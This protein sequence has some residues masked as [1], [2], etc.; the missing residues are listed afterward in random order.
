MTAGFTSHLSRRS[1]HEQ[2]LQE[3]W[4]QCYIGI[5]DASIYIH[6][7]DQLVNGDNIREGMNAEQLAQYIKETKAE[8]RFLRAYYYWELLRKYGPIPILPDE[9]VNFTDS[10][11]ELSIPRSR[12]DV[13]AEY[14]ASELALA[15]IDLPRRSERTNREVC[16]PVPKEQHWRL[17]PKYIC[18]PPV[19]NTWYE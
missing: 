11:E 3:Q 10:Y 17:G 18:L 4:Q 15:A 2:F 9:G 6:N 7:I 13:C 8:A 12:Y 1:I 19:R 5:R 16:K 14:I